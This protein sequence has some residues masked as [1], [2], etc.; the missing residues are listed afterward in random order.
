MDK[1][2]LIRTACEELLSYGLW[3]HKTRFKRTVKKYIFRQPI[4]EE[5]LIFWP[6][7]LLAVGLW[8]CRQEILARRGKETGSGAGNGENTGR[9]TQ[10]FLLQKI[11]TALSVYF[12]RWIRKEC[13][14]YYLDDL[15]AGEVVLAICE[16]YEK[17][18][19]ENG[20]VNEKNIAKYQ[21]AL[22]RLADYA[23]SYPT[24]ETGS[25]P[26]RANQQNGHIFVDSAG[27]TCPFLY[28]YG[29]FYDIDESMELA[30]KQ[31]A[32]FVAYGTDA[33]TGLPYHG[34]DVVT[35]NKYGIIGWG[36]S[37]GWLLRGMAGSMSTV[38]GLDRLKESFCN[39]LDAVLLWQR[40]D[41]YFSW[42]LQAMEGP[43]DTSA[44]A[45]IC[46]ALQ[47]G[48]RMRTLQG[49]GYQVALAKGMH[50]IHKSTK[51]GRV[52]DCLGECEGFAQYP[53]RYGDY[54]WALGVALMLDEK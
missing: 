20:I 6:T 33:A 5:D 53:Q 2:D 39:L 22:V 36:R 1:I 27:L 45:M 3:D 38:Y 13:P 48:I 47:E 25:F 21:S 43:A 26:Y 16:E 32:N 14:I 35:G 51:N 15:L 24:D 30:V 17:D 46:Y 19:A 8:H 50:A 41:G 52:Y 31:I 10:D 28:E 54:P 42:Q 12:T 11:E 9:E 4:A 40:K 34:Y 37:V 44:T 18:H 7:G 23:F 49:E 29:R